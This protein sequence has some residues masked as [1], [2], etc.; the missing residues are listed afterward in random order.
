[1]S[2]LSKS[3]RN[4]HKKWQMEAEAKGGKGAKIVVAPKDAKELIYNLLKDSFRP[5]NITGIYEALKATVPSPLLKSC[6]DSMSVSAADD[7]KG[8]QDS[9][10]EDDF[11]KSKKKGPKKVSTSKDPFKASLSTKIG[12]NANTTLYYCDYSKLPNEG[13]GLDP[14]ERNELFSESHKSNE[15]L[16]ENLK[17]IQT[18][19]QDV[20]LLLSQP[21]ND[22]IKKILPSEE[23]HV[24]D[25]KN[26]IDAARKLKVNESRLKSVKRQI[27]KM[28][29]IWRKRKRSCVDFLFMMEECTEGTI[30]AKKCLAGNGQMYVESDETTVKQM[31][32]I[33]ENKKNNPTKRRKVNGGK[34]MKATNDNGPEASPSFVAVMLGPQCTIQRIHVEE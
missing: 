23:S 6:L 20:T 5:M 13:N 12:R 24:E 19:D 10:D 27:E 9:D 34:M 15:E 22:E 8:S 25:L 28:S 31:K 4:I 2:K 18:T 3:S 33:Y 1:M 14:N 16:K 7:S 29:S 17:T 30:S 21:M 32:A 11:V 26:Q